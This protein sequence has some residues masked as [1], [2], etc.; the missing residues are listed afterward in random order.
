MAAYLVL[1][2]RSW[3]RPTGRSTPTSCV[4]LP[5]FATELLGAG[6]RVRMVFPFM[7]PGRR[8]SFRHLAEQ[9]G[10]GSAGTVLSILLHPVFGPWVSVRGALVTDADLT[11]TGPLRDFDPC[12]DCHPPCAASC[13]IDSFAGAIWDWDAC[14]RFRVLEAGCPSTCLARRA[15]V[16][17]VAQQ[18]SEKEYSYR[19]ALEPAAETHLR[20]EFDRGRT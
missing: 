18:Y 20:R 13:P 16:W 12:G 5:R 11:A 6:M 2:R 3:R 15:C 8:L 7:A 17:G 19:H 4:V 1:A 10:F 9:A 14:S